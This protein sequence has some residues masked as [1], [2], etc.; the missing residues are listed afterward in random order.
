MD[1]DDLG[2]AAVWG[3]ARS[4]QSESPGRVVLLDSDGT[5]P[6]S[7]ALATG[8]PQLA[9]RRGEVLVPRLTRTDAAEPAA[10]DPEGTV[11][12][13]GGTG[14]L[15]ST[16]A[17]HLVAEHGVRHLLLVARRGPDAPGAADLVADLA[18]LGAT[19]EVAACDVADREALAALLAAVPDAHPLTAVVHTAG[20][21]DDG[22]LTAQTPQRVDH[23]LRPKA[24]A[25]LHLD[26][27]TRGHDL[28]AFVL[29]SSAAG[30]LGSPGQSNY[31]AA[32]A[33]LDALAVR[34]RA[35]ALPAVS[36]A[37]G[38]WAGTGGMGDAADDTARRRIE[39][40]GVVPLTPEEGTRLFDAAVHGAAPWP[41][42][43]AW[44]WPLC[45]PRPAPCP[46]PRCCGA[47][48]ASRHVPPAPARSRP[49]SPAW[50][51]PPDAAWS[52]TPCA[53]PWPPPSATPAPPPSGTGAPSPT[54]ASTR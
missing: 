10:W 15:G 37:W 44:T 33:V 20:V 14:A 35:V 1:G 2:A 48:S 8:E 28:A 21:L 27:L 13:T 46:R 34:R 41:C 23:V 30:I 16:L 3:L 50:T 11:L 12:I 22:M 32:N 51:T 52:S 42:R 6:D 9:V 18:R 4:A 45:G 38:L 53:P 26:E 43:S 29:Y 47:W 54:S 25:A 5:V 17:R 39:R 40:L 24:E 49:H 19:A 31:A 36:L 7:V